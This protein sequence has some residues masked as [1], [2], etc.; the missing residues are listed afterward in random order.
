MNRKLL[1]GIF[2]A[3]IAFSSQVTAHQGLQGLENYISLLAEPNE[4]T[5]RLGL[6]LLITVFSYVGLLAT[7]LF[8]AKSGYGGSSV[9][10]GPAIIASVSI[11]VI[12]NFTL[13]GFLANLEIFIPAFLA[14]L[15]VLGLGA[16]LFYWSYKEN[17]S[18]SEAN[19]HLMLLVRGFSL[20]LIGIGL[21]ALSTAQV[22]RFDLE[23]VLGT[24]IIALAGIVAMLIGAY[25]LAVGFSHAFMAGRNAA[26]NPTTLNSGS[27]NSHTSSLDDDAGLPSEEVNR[28][29][30]ELSSDMRK[31][32]EASARDVKGLNDLFNR[33]RDFCATFASK[34]DEFIALVGKKQDADKD[35]LI[36]LYNELNR[37]AREEADLIYTN[38]TGRNNSLPVKV[39]DHLKKT[40]SILTILGGYLSKDKFKTFFDRSAKKHNGTAKTHPDIDSVV[41]NDLQA[42]ET[43][44]TNQKRHVSDALSILTRRPSLEKEINLFASELL[45]NTLK[46]PLNK[47]KVN[48]DDL[49]TNYVP[50]VVKIIQ[51]TSL[52][53]DDTDPNSLSSRIKALNEAMERVLNEIHT[54]GLNPAHVEPFFEQLKQVENEIREGPHSD[55]AEQDTAA[56]A[57]KLID[58]ALY[59]I[60]NNTN[61]SSIPQGQQGQQ[62]FS[63]KPEFDTLKNSYFVGA[64]KLEKYGVYLAGAVENIYTSD[65]FAAQGVSL[66]SVVSAMLVPASSVTNQVATDAVESI[67]KILGNVRRE[68]V[69]NHNKVERS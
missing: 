12:V 59:F 11:G 45:S 68:I 52:N 62:I 5:A 37:L 28:A 10:K 49:E 54:G 7:G 20:V 14:H 16:G 2:L 4:L 63:H 44:V 3:V 64:D 53:F 1:F 67:E 8:K 9:K 24:V 25:Y 23:Q 6:V 21:Y 66:Q 22:G 42:F 34:G 17:E 65:K 57:V 36:K 38:I 19:E 41:G 18:E 35:S 43:M 55:S 47:D 56:D 31:L 46:K 15:F 27:R 39:E 60:S 61:L 32:G 69:D 26:N 58:D 13:S 33:L 30:D 40:D 51:L 48:L 50:K 29:L